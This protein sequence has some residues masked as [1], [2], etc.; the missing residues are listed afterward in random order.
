V[1]LL[2]TLLL[3]FDHRKVAIMFLS[4][5]SDS[6]H[7]SSSST[8]HHYRPWLEGLEQRTLL[9][10]SAPIITP[11]G[12]S[13]VG[14]PVVGDFNGDGKLDVA[15]IIDL[16]KDN[17]TLVA[18]LFGNGNGTFQ[19]PVDYAAGTDAG[20]LQAG[21]FRGNGRLDLVVARA[22]YSSEPRMPAITCSSRAPSRSALAQGFSSAAAAVRCRNC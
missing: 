11:I 20:S 5:G 9:S 13:L 21:D 1:T 22:K 17:S 3:T 19:A 6:F 12:V 16:K 8:R 7:A 10:L 18:V 2:S 15:S 14:Q 4:R